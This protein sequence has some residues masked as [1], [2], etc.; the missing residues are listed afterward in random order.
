M[1]SLLI[2]LF[3]PLTIF[4]I[5]AQSA[6]EVLGKVRQVDSLMFHAGQDS[7]GRVAHLFVTSKS[8]DYNK[9]VIVS[10]VKTYRNYN[11]MVTFS[12]KADMFQDDSLVVT[13]LKE[14]KT[15]FINRNPSKVNRMDKQYNVKKHLYKHS[16]I[17][18]F[19]VKDSLAFIELTINRDSVPGVHILAFNYLYDLKKD[20]LIK[21]NTYYDMD[22]KL[23]RFLVL[24]QDYSLNSD[25]KFKDTALDY[26]YGF[27]GSLRKEY[28]DFKII[29]S[30]INNN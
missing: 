18:K 19:S 16:S 22:Y 5:P 8:F 28:R 7:S 29:D 21:S 25:F 30:R 1:R 12:N 10:N 23:S 11:Q 9:K 24:Y 3:I 4:I 26:V 6:K 27:K 14:E 2:I 15:I 13:V 17:H 20:K